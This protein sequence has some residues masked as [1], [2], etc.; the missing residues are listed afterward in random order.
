[1]ED[2]K[3]ICLASDSL[4]LN[5]DVSS[6]AQFIL[7]KWLKHYFCVHKYNTRIL[8]MKFHIKYQNDLHFKLGNSL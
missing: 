1:M 4:H 8:S 5:L 6:E 7:I 2:L 3:Q